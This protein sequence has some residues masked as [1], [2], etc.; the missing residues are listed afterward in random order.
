MTVNA[1]PLE[2]FITPM[3]LARDAEDKITTKLKYAMF[4][5]NGYMMS[6]PRLIRLLLADILGS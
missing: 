2:P 3:M 5:Q 4:I 1:L 6:L